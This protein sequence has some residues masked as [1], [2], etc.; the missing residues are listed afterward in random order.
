MKF[1]IKTALF[2]KTTLL[3]RLVLT[4]K[5]FSLHLRGLVLLID[6]VVTCGSQLAKTFSLSDIVLPIVFFALMLLLLYQTSI[7][8]GNASPFL[9]FTFSGFFWANE[10]LPEK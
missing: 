2:A 1:D 8:N 3:E 6:E 4:P 5:I 7:K 9:F 10:Y